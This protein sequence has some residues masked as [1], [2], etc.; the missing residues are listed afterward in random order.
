M[1]Q[2]IFESDRKCIVCDKTIV[3]SNYREKKIRE[4]RKFC[5]KRCLTIHRRISAY[6]FSQ[7]KHKK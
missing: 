2:K 5:G 3:V 7:V 6:T 1:S 4:A